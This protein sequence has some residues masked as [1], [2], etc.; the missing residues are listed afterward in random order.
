MY[1]NDEFELWNLAPDSTAVT[2]A[3]NIF[4]I[5]GRIK[6]PEKI[7]K[8]TYSINGSPERAVFFKYLKNNSERLMKAGD[9]NIDTVV[10]ED[11]LPENRMGF[12]LDLGSEEKEYHLNFPSRLSS[13]TIPRY[14]LDLSDASY[15]HEV[16]QIVDGRWFCGRDERSEPCIEILK[17]DAGLD[18]IILFGRRDWTSGYEITA[19]LCVTSWT[20]ITHNVGLLFKWNSHLQGDGSCLPAQWSTGLGYYYSLSRGLRIRLGQNVHFDNNGTKQGD[21]ILKERPLSHYYYLKGKMLKTYRGVLKLIKPDSLAALNPF[22]QIVPGRNYLFRM[23]VHP[24]RYE[25]TVWEERKKKPSPQLVADK[26]PEILSGGAVGVIA[27]NCGVRIYNFDV[28][29]L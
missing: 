25:L 6:H 18:R 12:R 11:L 14:R 28:S 3:Q 24:E 21:Y 9:F 23:L 2:G 5:L 15:P 10:L 29:P 22:S 17:K 8:I 7:K 27:Y 13:E 20:H 1:E 19:R 4:N 26:P 16:G